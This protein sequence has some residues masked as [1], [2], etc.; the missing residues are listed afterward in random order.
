MSAPLAFF[1]TGLSPY[2]QYPLIVMEEKGIV[3]T[4]TAVDLV[5]KPQWFVDAAPTGRVPALRLDDGTVLCESAAI[6]EYL[7]EVYAPRMLPADPVQRARHR[8]WAQVAGE[9]VSGLADVYMAPDAA[10]LAAATETFTRRLAMLD[11]GLADWPAPASGQSLTLADARN[12][13]WTVRYDALARLGAL[14]PLAD[15][16]PRLRDYVARLRAQPSL[17]RT[18]PN[19]FDA[20]FAASVKRRGGAIAAAFT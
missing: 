7:E 5:S 1:G 2:A 8:M 14:H 17:R 11:R 10:R 19:G 13:P 3:Y 16:R 4:A 15:A 9:L 12:A 18:T 20:L 6:V